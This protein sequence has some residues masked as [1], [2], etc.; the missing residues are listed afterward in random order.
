MSVPVSISRAADVLLAG[1]VIAYPTEGVFGLGCLPDET[2]AVL[3]VLQIK[4]RGPAKGLILIA[5]EREQL[6]DWIAP[7]GAA[8]PDPDPQRPVTWV[9]A[10]KAGSP[11]LVRG[12]HEGIAVRLTT[13][14]VA[15]ALCAA[16][17]S[18]LVSTSANTSG[19]PVARNR[20]VLRRR[21]GSCVDYIVPGD[22][23]PASGPSEIR[24]LQTRGVLRPRRK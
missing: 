2:S 7:G 24:V 3:R 20:Y 5:S 15:A 8:I 14:P 19:G 22:C 18:A 1:G 12:E 4:R 23:G 21:F 9:V 6:D 10:A 17:G 16:A 11:Q 13:H